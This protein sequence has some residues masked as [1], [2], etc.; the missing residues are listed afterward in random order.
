MNKEL[1]KTSAIVITL[2]CLIGN[3]Y[4]ATAAC[5]ATNAITQAFKRTGTGEIV[6]YTAPGPGGQLWTGKNPMSDQS[7]LRQ[8][9]FEGAVVHSNKGQTFVACRYLDLNNEAM[10]MTLK[11]QVNA[12]PVGTAWAGKECKETNPALCTF[13]YW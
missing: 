11:N 9:K 7:D 13:H 1:K 2:M 4:A 12:T 6:V 8:V 10:S 5:P 3:A